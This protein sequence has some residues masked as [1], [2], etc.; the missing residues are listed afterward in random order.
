MAKEPIT[1]RLDADTKR[2]VENYADKHEIGQTEAA[3]RLIRV[4]LANEGHPVTASDGGTKPLLERVASPRTVLG[5]VLLMVLSL[6]AMIP[7]GELAQAGAYTP[8]LGLL[9]VATVAAVMAAIVIWASALAQL[10][11]ARPLRAL[12]LPRSETA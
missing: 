1:T 8:A 9:L 6:A 3:R 7:A 4:G 11:L 5:G 10:A 2:E 12:I